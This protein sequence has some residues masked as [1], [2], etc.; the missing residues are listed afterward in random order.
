MIREPSKHL[1]FLLSTDNMEDE[2]NPKKL[3][4]LRKVN[5]SLSV[6]KMF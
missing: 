1:A 5:S 3:P 4:G 6:M 2:V